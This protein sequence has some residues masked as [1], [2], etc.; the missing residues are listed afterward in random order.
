MASVLAVLLIIAGSGIVLFRGISTIMEN[1]TSLLS[2]SRTADE[3]L[4]EQ[5]PVEEFSEVGI[6]E[7]GNQ[8][9]P[10]DPVDKN[11]VDAEKGQRADLTEPGNSTPKAS[12]R[13]EQ[14]PV[15][16][17]S[18]E[19]RD[20]ANQF[21]RIPRSGVMIPRLEIEAKSYVPPFASQFV[22]IDP[23][24]RMKE[25]FVNQRIVAELNGGSKTGLSERTFGALYGANSPSMRSRIAPTNETPAIWGYT[26]IS[27]DTSRSEEMRRYYLELELMREK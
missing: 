23:S 11:A 8:P 17:A 3:G 6:E 21:R 19:A 27:S 4:D 22:D 25:S 5:T 7:D 18:V 2:G 16:I 26:S 20:P 1:S 14:F 15:E 9:G 12:R 24:F 13:P 10:Q